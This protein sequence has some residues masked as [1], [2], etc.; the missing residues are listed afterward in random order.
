MEYVR[1]GLE[2]GGAFSYHDIRIDLCATEELDRT[3]PESRGELGETF[4]RVRSPGIRARDSKGTPQG[5][6]APDGGYVVLFGRVE[7]MLWE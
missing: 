1:Q 4:Q 5:R 7:V 3:K 2:G 6:R